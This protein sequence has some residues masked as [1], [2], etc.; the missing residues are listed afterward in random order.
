MIKVKQRLEISLDEL[1]H[2]TPK[3]TEASLAVNKSK[4]V[5]Y[6][7]A[8]GGGKSFF[9]RWKLLSMLLGYAARGK[10]NVT[11]GLFCED[12]PALRDRHVGK[13]KA[14]FPEWLGEYR[15]VD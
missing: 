11:V 14:E 10:T 6:G 4:F 2:F 8:M 15:E 5:L 1:R 13:I 7:G 12:Y 3:Q 9:L